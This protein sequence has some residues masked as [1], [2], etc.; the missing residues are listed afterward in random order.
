MGLAASIVGRFS[1]SLN[2]CCRLTTADGSR[3]SPAEIGRYGERIAKAWLWA[4]GAKVLYQN[5]KAPRGGEVDVVARDGTLL[6]FTEVKTRSS[7]EYG[8]PLEAVNLEKQKLIRRGANEWLRL[9]GTHEIPWRYDV[10]EVIL[11]DG[12]K[13][14]VH[15]VENAF[16]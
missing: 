6:L 9:L 4:S 3:L 13:P 1:R 8:R 16:Q 12:E 7:T 11:K 15:R 2:S 14:Q 10:I 5:F